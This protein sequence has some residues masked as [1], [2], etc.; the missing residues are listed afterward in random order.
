MISSKDGW[1]E[2]MIHGIDGVG[3]GQCPIENNNPWLVL[4]FLSFLLLMGFFVINL[5]IGVVI[6]NFN[7]YRMEKLE[8]KI[9]RQKSQRQQALL[10]TELLDTGELFRF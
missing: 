7:K 3:Q 4:Y 9:D 1:V 6:E 10:D 8:V 5:F 2:I